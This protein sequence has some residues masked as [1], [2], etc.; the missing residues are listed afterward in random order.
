MMP[1]NRYPIIAR[2]AWPFL[3]IFLG[4]VV[5]AQF[6]LGPYAFIALLVVF[7]FFVYLF[8]DPNREIPSEPLAVVSPV[9]GV[10]TL[11]EEADEI[12]LHTRAIRVQITMRL[13]DIYSLRGPIEGK[14][15]E[16]WCSAPDKNEARRHF[17]FHIKSD[18]GDNVV[19]A[20]RL[21]DITRKFHVYMHTGERVGQG[22]RCGYLYFGGVVDVFLPIESK[23][24]VELG[25]QVTSG[26]TVLA[27]LIH[28]EA[29]SVIQ[30][31]ES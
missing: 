5:L 13:Y 1:S 8:R 11:I 7:T 9:H 27:R 12:R 18:E 15:V 16:Q 30:N 26:S 10:I 28:S 3:F 19:T 31:G 2:E 21:R 20:I 23:V 17:D 22:Q 6:F 29:A 24:Q 4:M 14:V 25:Q